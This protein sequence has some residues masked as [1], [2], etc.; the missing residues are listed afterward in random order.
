MNEQQK[1]Y[2]IK[3]RDIFRNTCMTVALL[4]FAV[5]MQ[6][7]KMHGVNSDYFAIPFLT[8]AGSAVTAVA[9]FIPWRSVKP[10][11]AVPFI[12]HAL[13]A[14][15]ALFIGIAGAG[16]DSDQLIVAVIVAAAAAVSFWVRGFINKGGE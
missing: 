14:V 3:T 6:G 10:L 13:T 12:P 16:G 15:A 9:L 2:V 7:L 8:A 1:A 11:A 4:A 5:S